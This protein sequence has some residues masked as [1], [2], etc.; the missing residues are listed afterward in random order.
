M[1]NEALPHRNF[2]IK[3]SVVENFYDKALKFKRPRLAFCGRV[4]S[5]RQRPDFIRLRF[6]GDQWRPLV[7]QA[8][9]VV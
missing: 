3:I 1:T 5:S 4:S 2:S 7:A 6:E 8:L 9:R